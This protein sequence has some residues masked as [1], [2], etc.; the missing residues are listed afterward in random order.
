MHIFSLC[1]WQSP[2]L[3]KFLLTKLPASESTSK[4]AFW[5]SEL[6]TS[7]AVFSKSSAWR[8]EQD[9]RH[10]VNENGGKIPP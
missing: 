6:K 10:T 8:V 9:N 4:Q 5:Y 2:T 7:N 3:A 1:F